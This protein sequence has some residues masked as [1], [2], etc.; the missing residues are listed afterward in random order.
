MQSYFHMK[1]NAWHF[2]NLSKSLPPERLQLQNF[3]H[4]V[5]QRAVTVGFQD[6]ILQ[7]SGMSSAQQPEKPQKP[8]KMIHLGQ[9]ARADSNL[10]S[11]ERVSG[12]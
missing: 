11:K 7:N 1:C 8:R 2:A 9:K 10:G 12:S 5:L 6:V 4:W 3:L